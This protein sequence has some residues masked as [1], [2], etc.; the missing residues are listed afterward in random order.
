MTQYPKMHQMTGNFHT[1]FVQV[2]KTQNTNKIRT[3]LHFEG[4]RKLWNLEFLNVHSYCFIRPL[5]FSLVTKLQYNLNN[6]FFFNN[7]WTQFWS[8]RFNII[9]FLFLSLF[10]GHNSK[11][12]SNLLKFSHYWAKYRTLKIII[13]WVFDSLSSLEIIIFG[14]NDSSLH[15]N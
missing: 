10:F 5:I 3:D 7:Y 1:P 12:C 2:I 11:N 15:T 4:I 6:I 14:S 9:I 8:K 13:C